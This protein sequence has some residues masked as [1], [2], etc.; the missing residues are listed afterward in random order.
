MIENYEFL[1]G[2]YHQKMKPVLS[3]QDE[4]HRRRFNG[5]GGS[6]MAS[7]LGISKYQSAYDLWLVKT[8]RKEPFRRPW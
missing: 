7:V 8:G 6:E 5:I 1:M 2:Q 3:A 4:W